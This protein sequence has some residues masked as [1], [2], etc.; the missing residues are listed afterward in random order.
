MAESY[1]ETKE[2]ASHASDFLY[3][4]VVEPLLDSISSINFSYWLG[5]V[6][7][8]TDLKFF[9]APLIS[10]GPPMSIFSIA[11]SNLTFFLLIH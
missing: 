2:Y 10:D 3:S 1:D 11:S 6:R 7:T 9:A 4:K 5:F 8:Q